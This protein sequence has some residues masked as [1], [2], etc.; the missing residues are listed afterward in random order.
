MRVAWQVEIDPFCRDILAQHWPEVPRYQCYWWTFEPAL[1]RMV[2]RVPRSVDR[3]AREK[4]L[5]NCV[6][7]QCAE[8]LGRVILDLEAFEAEHR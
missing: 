3:A 6:V 4:A 7:P 1:A 8:Y 2:P 5:G